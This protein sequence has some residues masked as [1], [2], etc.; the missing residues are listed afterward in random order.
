MRGIYCIIQMMGLSFGLIC[1][2]ACWKSCR[3]WGLTCVTS[4]VSHTHVIIVTV[5]C[6]PLS[7]QSSV[8]DIRY[9][10]TARPKIMEQLSTPI[11]PTLSLSLSLSFSLAKK[12]TI[13]VFPWFECALFHCRLIFISHFWLVVFLSSL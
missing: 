3:P 13:Q 6:A 7:S 8:I 5:Q 9:Q 12:D 2:L 10:S 11:I 4:L 1:G